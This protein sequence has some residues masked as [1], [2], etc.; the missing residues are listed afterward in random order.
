MKKYLARL[1]IILFVCMTAS[2]SLSAISFAL[3]G[4]VTLIAVTFVSYFAWKH[5]NDFTNH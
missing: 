5:T 4:I 1:L 2:I 3:Q